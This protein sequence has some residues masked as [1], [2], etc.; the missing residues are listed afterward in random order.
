[1]VNKKLAKE[2]AK[3]E[4][5]KRE[6]M[7]LNQKLKE[8]QKNQAKIF[9][10]VALWKVRGRGLASTLLCSVTKTSHTGHPRA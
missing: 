5:K 9:C 3:L 4:V 7:K 2:K 10:G 1:L 6:L 8:V